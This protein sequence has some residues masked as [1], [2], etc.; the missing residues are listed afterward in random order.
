MTHEIHKLSVKCMVIQTFPPKT[1]VV[2]NDYIQIFKLKTLVKVMNGMI[3][4][5]SNWR[6][7]IPLHKKFPKVRIAVS[8]QPKLFNTLV[9]AKPTPTTG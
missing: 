5:K 1:S 7:L 6:V 4:F 9:M 2:W 3:G 8:Q